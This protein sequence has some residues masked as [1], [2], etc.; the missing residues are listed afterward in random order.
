MQHLRL[1]AFS[2]R[3][4]IRSYA[5]PTTKNVVNI[6]EVSPRD[7]LQN[8]KG[9][10]PVS[11]KAELVTRLGRA[12]VQI[13]E[14]GSFVSPKWVPQMAGTAE[15]LSQMERLQNVRYQVLVP[16]QKG[17]DAVTAL[18]AE[19]PVSPPLT[20]EISI[21]TAA[22]DAFTRA[23]LNTTTAESLA[24]LAP[25]ARAA[26]DHGLRV[27]GYVSVVIACPYSGQVDY[28]RVREVTKA[29]LDMGCYEVSLG[30]TVGM[31]T[32]SQVSEMLDEVK[33]DVPVEKLA[34]HFHDTYGT[35]V[36]NVLTALDHGVRTIDASVGGLGGCPYSPGATGNV[37]TEDVLYALQ[38]SQYHVAGN[39]DGTIDLNKMVDIGWWISEQLGRESVSRVGR[40]IRS[41][42]QAEV[43][44]KL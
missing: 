19:Q 36:A 10:I 25:V 7:G 17:L 33:K 39:A 44:A 38:G 22:T 13:I 9:V 26:L 41:R 28:I 37:A 4:G 29:L 23:N 14:A 30:D 21:F 8:E 1:R 35:A 2:R 24:R 12:G 34:G 3:L 11:V 42:R 27:R 18:L 20:D 15:V 31:G 43:R 16:N 32:P 5:I 6:V 40:A